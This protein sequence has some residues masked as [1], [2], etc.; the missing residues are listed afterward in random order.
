MGEC[1]CPA[2]G[3]LSLIDAVQKFSTEE[4]AEAWFI[5]RRWPD[6]VKCPHCASAEISVRKNRKPMPFHCR[7]CRQYFSI[8]TGT[9]LH[10][11]K[12]PLSKWALAFY[13]MSVNRKGVSSVQLSKALGV[14]QKTAWHL[15]H[16][17]RDAWALQSEK[18]EGPVEVDE[19]Y[20]G[21]REKNKHANK[22]LHAGRGFVGKTGVA[23]ARDRA[24]N[25]VQSEIIPNATKRTLHDF[26]ERHIAEDATVYTD[27]HGGYHN[28]P[29][30]HGSVS[31]SRG[32]YV[33][34]AVSTNGIESHWAV[35]KRGYIGIYHWM[36]VKHLHR[37]L[38]EF[39]GR[40]NTKAMSAL[41]QMGALVA[42]AVGKRLPYAKLVNA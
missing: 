35:L 6:G 18:F 10:A 31:H 16:R 12:L 4:A 37:Y 3:D 29:R 21:G 39:D 19:T 8:R 34:G 13:L 17:I 26:V 15:E 32:E 23:G 2:D 36:S 41:D 20:I 5:D 25:Q 1:G 38:R 7:T 27:E 42:G 40:H 24:T 22:K 33:N 9:L 30:P 14:T 28:L 11:S